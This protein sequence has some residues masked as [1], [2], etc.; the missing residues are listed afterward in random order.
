MTKVEAEDLSHDELM[1][2]TYECECG[3]TVTDE[4][5]VAEELEIATWLGH[6]DHCYIVAGEC[7][8]AARRSEYEM[9]YYSGWE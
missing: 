9:D 2:Y 8:E 3:E 5:A 4:D 6:A 7:G 1:A